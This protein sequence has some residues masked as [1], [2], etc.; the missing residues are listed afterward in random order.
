[1]GITPRLGTGI[2]AAH[3]RLL[4]NNCRLVPLFRKAGQGGSFWSS[5][6]SLSSN[7][8]MNPAAANGTLPSKTSVVPPR[9][10]QRIMN[11]PS[12]I[13]QTKINRLK[14][15]TATRIRTVTFLINDVWIRQSVSAA[16]AV[17]RVHLLQ[18]FLGYFRNYYLPICS[19][20]LS[21][22]RKKYIDPGAETRQYGFASNFIGRVQSRHGTV[23]TIDLNC[24]SFRIHNPNK[25]NGN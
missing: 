12:S 3:S 13:F 15:L 16:L 1:M 4:Q 19:R 14:T 21:L 18:S 11:S 24:A 5:N 10:N 8:E 20:S 6:R 23:W 9:A 22:L 17:N 2:R 7:R 25:R